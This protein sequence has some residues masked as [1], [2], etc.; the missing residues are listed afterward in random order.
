[1]S[2]PGCAPTA[3]SGAQWHVRNRAARGGAAALL[4]ALIA[5]SAGAADHPA[6]GLKLTRLPGSELVAPFSVATPDRGSIALG[7]LR[8]KVVLL[9]FWATWCEPC[10]EEMPALERVGRTYQ[11]RGLVVLA[12]SVDREGA[13]LVVPFLKRHALTFPVGLDPQQTVAHLY[14]LRALPST[15][16]GRKG[17]AL[18]SVQGARDWDGPMGHSLFDSLLGEASRVHSLRS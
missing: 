9:N 13:P 11:D 5:G 6:Q 10:L 12:L 7:D 15:I 18:F 4:L 16:I 3:E 8:G 1:M 14:R 2:F 17:T